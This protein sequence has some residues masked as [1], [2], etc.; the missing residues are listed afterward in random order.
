MEG[1]RDQ[2]SSQVTVSSSGPFLSLL[3]V[4]HRCETLTRMCVGVCAPP[5]LV[6]TAAPPVQSSLVTQ[7]AAKTLGGKH[8]SVRR[9]SADG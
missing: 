7:S 2:R 3:F 4:F 1:R 9:R 5:P 6:N 8:P